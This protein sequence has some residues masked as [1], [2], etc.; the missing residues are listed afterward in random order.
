MQNVPQEFDRNEAP[1]RQNL[2]VQV[3]LILKCLANTFQLQ[4]LVSNQLLQKRSGAAS[5]L[6]LR[7]HFCFEFARENLKKT[8]T[9][10]SLCIPRAYFP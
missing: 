8:Y 10:A 5:M 6:F 2:L 9:R 3:A 1:K 7:E 4:V